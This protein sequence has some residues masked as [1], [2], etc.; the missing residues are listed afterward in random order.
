MDFFQTIT[1]L[2]YFTVVL[3]IMGLI[4]TPILELLIQW[5]WI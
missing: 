3:P 2:F 5:G 4:P 1:Y